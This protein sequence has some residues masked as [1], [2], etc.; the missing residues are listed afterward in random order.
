MKK[1]ALPIF[2]ICLSILLL[3][4]LDGALPENTAA[5][6]ELTCGRVVCHNIPVNAGNAQMSITFNNGDS[7]YM[8]DSVYSV[9]VKI[10]DPMTMRNGFQILALGQSNQNAGTWQLTEPAKMKVIPGISFPN[11]KYVT[12][13]A[14][15]NLQNEWIMNWKAPS[16]SVGK[17][18][19]YASVLSAN[20]NGMNTGDEVYNTKIE[21]QLAMPS[22]AGEVS[23]SDFKIY[24]APATSGF[25]VEMLEGL[26][27]SRFSLYN[28]S[29]TNVVAQT[30][31]RVD[32]H[33]IETSGLPGGVYLLVIE[34]EKRRI[35]KKIVLQE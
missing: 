6:S 4:N 3:A 29:G 27:A 11:R 34:S 19:F 31:S 2:A 28:S 25:W 5:P 33:Y 1:I 20:N 8:A 7:T 24:P 22:A 32:R 14:A 23:E 9:K 17:V 18:T 12:H 35:I 13:Q 10:E 21:V 26:E 15:G 30:E 16:V